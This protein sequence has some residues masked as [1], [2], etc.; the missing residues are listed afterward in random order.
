[1]G[2]VPDQGM[3][4]I[5]DALFSLTIKEK[6]DNFNPEEKFYTYKGTILNIKIRQNNPKKIYFKALPSRCFWWPHDE[7]LPEFVQI[8]SMIK[9]TYQ[10][11]VVKTYTHLWIEKFD[12]VEVSTTHR[13]KCSSGEKS[14]KI[15]CDKCEYDCLLTNFK[16]CDGIIEKGYFGSYCSVCRSSSNEKNIGERCVKESTLCG[17]CGNL[18]NI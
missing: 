9:V 5:I 12:Q 10:E 18:R 3:E 14:P 13:R 6:S 15:K 4:K 16:R 2:N 11:I 17:N 7:N 1:M 8:G